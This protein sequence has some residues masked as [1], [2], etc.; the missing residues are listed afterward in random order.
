LRTEDFC[1]EVTEG[2]FTNTHAIAGLEEARRLGFSVSMDDFGVGYS[3]LAQLPRL[4]L[5]SVKL[6][7]SFIM[8]A[9][10]DVGEAVM[11]SSIVDL[12]HAQ[13][14][15]V[16]A[17]GIETV[18]QLNLAVKSGCDAVQGYYFARPMAPPVMEQWLS[19]RQPAGDTALDL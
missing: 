7:R 18:E 5:A 10:Q 13:N 4:P 6:D 9:A 17:E 19:A 2:A 14:L 1:I 8:G 15:S 11:L 16:I 12:A 3:C